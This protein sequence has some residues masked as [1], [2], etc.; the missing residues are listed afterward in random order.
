MEKE[1]TV[2][3]AAGFLYQK[4]EVGQIT[5]KVFSCL[6][7]Q[8]KGDDEFSM[9]AK[10]ERYFNQHEDIGEQIKGFNLVAWSFAYE[11]R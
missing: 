7:P 9:K 1:N 10:A 2:L 11:I 5:N 3:C 4:Q 8:S 6:I